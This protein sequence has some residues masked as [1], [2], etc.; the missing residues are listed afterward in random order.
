MASGS[1]FLVESAAQL[2]RADER[3]TV[4]GD[5]AE[6]GDGSWRG[7][8]GIAGLALRRQAEPWRGWRPWVAGFGL[9]LPWSFL[10]MGASVSVSWMIW[11]M[12]HAAAGS[13]SFWLLIDKVL[14][15]LLVAWA[16]GFLTGSVS[17]RTLWTSVCLAMLPCLFC[18]SRFGIQDVPSQSLLVFVPPAVLG[19]WQGRRRKRVGRWVAVGLGAGATILTLATVN[20]QGVWWLDLAFLLP[21]WLVAWVARPRGLPSLT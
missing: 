9:A 14:L 15:L 1:W 17:R 6:A 20:P 16:V 13:A 10:L 12:V 5:L 21:A 3:E 7:I 2:L 4:L 18:F 11:G 19:A 8:A